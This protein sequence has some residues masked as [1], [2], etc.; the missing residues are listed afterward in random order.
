MQA[1]WIEVPVSDFARATKFY[2]T[3]LGSD[4]AIKNMAGGEVS[5]G[6]LPGE[7]GLGSVCLVAGPGYKPADEGAVIYLSI[8][9]DLAPVLDRVEA[10]GGAVL[11]PKSSIGPQGFRA[12]FRDSEGN[13]IGL[14]SAR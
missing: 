14:H 8:G 5:F 2:R 11:L 1:H 3:I 4:D 7:R 13:R 9:D 6:Y 10:A 12:Q